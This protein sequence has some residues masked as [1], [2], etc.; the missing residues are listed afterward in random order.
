MKIEQSAIVLNL[1]KQMNELRK[2]KSVV[3]SEL[4]SLKRSS[5]ACAFS[6]M[7]VEVETYAQECIRMRSAYY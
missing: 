2:Q 5:Q 3:E 1:R 6:E 4:E 7:D